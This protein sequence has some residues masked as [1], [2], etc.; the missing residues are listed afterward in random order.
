MTF[1]RRWTQYRRAQRERIAQLRTQPHGAEPDAALERPERAAA[2]D[3]P[4]EDV[5]DTLPLG[6]DPGPDAGTGGRARPGRDYGS[7]GTPFNRQSP[8][9]V[10]FVGAIGVLTAYA[11]VQ[12]VGR[13]DTT[14]TL[15]VVSL[16]L[17]LALNPLVEGLTRQNMRRGLA[18][19]IVF[20]GLL[21]VFTLLGMVVVPPVASEGTDLADNAP[22]M[23]DD[24]LRQPWVQDVD[25]RYQ[26]VQRI[27]EEINHRIADGNLWAG[28]FG[29]VLGA[30]RIIA[31]G[32]FSILT[33]LV[34]TL[35]FLAS[36]P[37]VKQ[38][39]Y[40]LVPAS[41]RPRFISLAEE[42]MRRVGS[43]AIGQVAVAATNA[44]FAWIM[45]SLLDL[46]FAAVLAV[47]VGLLGLIPMIGATLGASVVA[48][49]A[50]FDEP[51]K[52]LVVIIYFVIYQQLE[53]YA[54]MPRIMQ[55]TVAVPGALTVVAALAGG[56][57]LGILGA[58]LA[59]PFAAG[60][61]L[62]YEEVLVPRQLRH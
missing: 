27:Q 7:A 52:A 45:M 61:M 21:G 2:G 37:S 49:V 16:F 42:I 43:Y 50:F 53:N 46:P 55:R 18:V 59:I 24:L 44:F 4:R 40:A 9:Y 62:I 8:F 47:A 14:I 38:A 15:L 58:L 5:F 20:L 35:Y 48:L 10:G 31:A 12:A 25:H 17:T 39:G 26:V 11:V 56:T 28:I 33:V 30:G 19:T 29:G 36:L 13:L 32:V 57:L 54:V 34:L 22:R 6:G 60:A 23:L 51:K 1:W 3:P 41:R